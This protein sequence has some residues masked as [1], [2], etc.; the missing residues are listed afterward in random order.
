[1]KRILFSAAMLIALASTADA[2]FSTYPRTTEPA[3]W[4]SG[5]VG[6]FNAQRVND[7]STASTWDFGEKTSWQYR[8][9]IEKAIQNESSIGIVGTFVRL[10][11]TYASTTLGC[12]ACATTGS[13]GASCGSCAAHLD[14]MSL[15]LTFHSGGGAGF[16]QVVEI[17]AGATAYRNLKRDA[18]GAALA[19]SGGNIDPSF[20]LGYGY[21]YGLSSNSEIMIVGDY[22][23][24][25]HESKNLPSGT[26]NTN[27]VRSIRMGL[28]F[29]FG[30]RPSGVRRR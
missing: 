10:P 6:T 26:S 9:S 12:A 29:G 15:E 21:G 11:F 27:T 30:T 5:G 16:H 24:I 2:Q 28:R 19:P 17:G 3:Y 1:M 20:G 4:L 7:G 13:A 14:L 8:G 23:L 18:D 25:L 22:R